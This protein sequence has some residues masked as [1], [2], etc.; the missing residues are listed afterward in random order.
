MGFGTRQENW[1]SEQWSKY[2]NDSHN[3][4]SP[5]RK[6]F[7]RNFQGTSFPSLD[8]DRM[9][10]ARLAEDPSRLR[11]YLA[12]QL[13][14]STIVEKGKSRFQGRSTIYRTFRLEKESH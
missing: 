7:S 9:Y 5:P 2:T 10:S 1:I 4:A 14:Y 8:V 6:N 11:D 3:H 12:V 13:C